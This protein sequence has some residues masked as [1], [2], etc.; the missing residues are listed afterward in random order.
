MAMKLKKPKASK[1]TTGAIRRRDRARVNLTRSECEDLFHDLKQRKSRAVGDRLK[2]LAT[3]GLK[4]EAAGFSLAGGQPDGALLNATGK[5]T[6]PRPVG[7][8]DLDRDSVLEDV[9][10]K[11]LQRAS[12]NLLGIGA[13]N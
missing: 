9:N 4:A 5:T 7:K 3:L 12:L 11:A 6:S 13:S 10:Q 2:Y 1:K 8:H